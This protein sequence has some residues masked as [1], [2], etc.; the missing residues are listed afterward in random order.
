MPFASSLQTSTLNKKI[1]LDIYNG[2]VISRHRVWPWKSLFFYDV[3]WTRK[4][5]NIVFYDDGWYSVFIGRLGREYWVGKEGW[6]NPT[7]QMNI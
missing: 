5:K 6:E 1:H 4:N 7:E 3:V 2:P